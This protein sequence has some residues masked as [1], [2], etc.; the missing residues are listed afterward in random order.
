MLL[1]DYYMANTVGAVNIADAETEARS[2]K[3]Y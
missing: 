1:C 2:H 3:N